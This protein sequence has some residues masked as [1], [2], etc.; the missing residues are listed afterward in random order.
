[1]KACLP[2]LS[3]FQSVMVEFDILLS[4]IYRVPVLNLSLNSIIF[5]LP[6]I[7]ELYELLVPAAL[8][9]Q[10]DGFGVLGGLSYGVSLAFFPSSA[11]LK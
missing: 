9:K 3:G 4:P 11:S 7:E 8:R 6:T 1:M 10:I 2:R 5:K